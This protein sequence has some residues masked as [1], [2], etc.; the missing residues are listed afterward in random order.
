MAGIDVDYDNRALENMI[1]TF[2]DNADDWLNGVAQQINGEIVQSFGDSP[3]GES[4]TRGGVTH[5]ASVAGYPPNVDTGSLRA[6]MKVTRMGHL[7]YRISD[8]V[9]YGI[10]LEEG[11]RDIEARPFVSPVIVEW[12]R[13][14]INEARKLF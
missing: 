13:K 8:G 1:A 2:G 11:T 5:V 4:Y 7:H 10:Y 14:I 3:S 9:E 12:G 6:S